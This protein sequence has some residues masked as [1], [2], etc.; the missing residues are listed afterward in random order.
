MSEKSR[1]KSRTAPSIAAERKSDLAWEDAANFGE[2]NSHTSL[3]VKVVI[4]LR[5][6]TYLRNTFKSKYGLVHSAGGCESKA[7]I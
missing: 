2:W 7:V 6:L 5:Y 1:D 3:D 4:A